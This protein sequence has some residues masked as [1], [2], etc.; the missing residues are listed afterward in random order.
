[1]SRD[2][3]L[4]N[5]LIKLIVWQLGKTAIFGALDKSQG[6]EHPMTLKINVDNTLCCVNIEIRKCSDAYVDRDEN[7]TLFDNLV[8][9]CNHEI[10]DY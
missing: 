8:S 6:V 10:I 5:L 4:E 2:T 9:R 3:I 1:M 7:L